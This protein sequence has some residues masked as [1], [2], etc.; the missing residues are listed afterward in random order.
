MLT[1]WQRHSP[2]SRRPS[3]RTSRCSNPH[4][5]SV[6]LKNFAAPWTN[7]DQIGVRAAERL[8]HARDGHGPRQRAVQSDPDGRHS[9]HGARAFRPRRRPRATTTTTWRSRRACAADVQSEPSSSQ[10]TQSGTYGTAVRGDRGRDHD[11]RGGRGVLHRRHEPRDVPLHADQPHVQ[12]MEQVHDTSITPDRIRQDVS[13]S[14]GGDSRVFLNSCIGCH[15]GMDPLAQAFAYY[16]YDET[17]QRLDLH[18]AASCS[19]STSTTTRRSPT[20]SSRRTTL[21]QPLAPGSERADRLELGLCPVGQR[22]EVARPRARRHARVRAVPGQEG[23]QGGLPARSG[24]PGRPRP[25][26]LD[27]RRL[28]ERY[29]LK[30]VFAESAKYCM[31]Q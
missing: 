30:P 25:G 13:R 16:N 24:R 21:E 14:P 27:D 15:A 20:A 12:D 23:L 11:A 8:H 31:G 7:R 19:R 22:R 10:T 28:H 17:T 4:F 5:Y 9:L 2:A 18:A 6:T 29:N 1:R 26:R 3:P